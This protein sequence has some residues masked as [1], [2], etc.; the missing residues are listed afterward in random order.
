MGHFKC[1]TSSYQKSE[2]K[3]PNVIFSENCIL[4]L[5]LDRKLQGKLP[6][7]ENTIKLRIFDTHIDLLED[8]QM[9]D[10]IKF[11]LFWA[12]ETH[13]RT[14]R[15]A[16]KEKR[17]CNFGVRILLPIQIQLLDIENPKNPTIDSHYIPITL[18]KEK[19]EYNIFLLDPPITIE[20]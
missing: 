20:I 1:E 3:T 14:G 10:P 9:F 16:N 5:T 2:P 18:Y 7:Y 17:L 11:S 4:A 19:D 8:I 13:L 15:H 6:H 12:K